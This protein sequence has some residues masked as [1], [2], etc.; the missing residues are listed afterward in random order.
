MKK[1]F[2]THLSQIERNGYAIIL[3]RLVHRR[4]LPPAIR[5]VDNIRNGMSFLQIG[6][7]AIAYA[8]LR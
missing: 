3:A 6:I 5:P 2:E 7:V 4:T 1:K 8:T